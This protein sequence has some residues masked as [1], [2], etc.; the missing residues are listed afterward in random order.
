[1]RRTLAMLP[2]LLFACA[3]SEEGVAY[4]LAAVKDSSC[5][6]L[7]SEHRGYWNG[8]NNCL[9]GNDFKSELQKKIRNYTPIHY[10]N[11]AATIPADFNI[12]S[13]NQPV[14]LRFDIW[15]TIRG[16]G[17][18]KIQPMG[19]TC[20]ANQVYDWY[21]GNCY[22]LANLSSTYS[23]ITPS[24]MFAA[25]GGNETSM[26]REHAW[27]SSWFDAGAE[28]NN[29]SAGSYCY[30]GRSDPG[31]LNH[32]D[33]RA[34]SDAH[35]LLPTQSTINGTRSNHPYGVVLT[36]DGGFPTA[37]G[38]KFGVP[39]ATGIMTGVPGGVTKV[40]E[41][42]DSMKGDIARIYFYMSTRYYTED[43]CWP[44]TFN[45][46]TRA[47]INSWQENVLRAWH[48]ADPVSDGERARNDLIHRIQGNRNPF[49]DHPEWVDKIS[50]F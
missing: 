47:S 38:N 41:P 3:Q 8:I 18:K 42:A 33:Y 22:T 44:T 46:T 16:M 50:D 13:F 2:L 21:G 36:N 20:G 48:T 17:Y 28:V 11:D 19:T 43:T 26:N 31:Y 10:T 25:L 49:V 23:T 37:N 4:R 1:M 27:P 9:S 45:A 7:S 14:P 5:S 32:R 29:P 12:E 6:V 39:S 15:D 30:N 34:F 35:H 24:N 40:F